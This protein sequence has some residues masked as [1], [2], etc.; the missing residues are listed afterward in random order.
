[1]TDEVQEAKQAYSQHLDGINSATDAE[2]DEAVSALCNSA[3]QTREPVGYAGT[4]GDMLGRHAQ[5]PSPHETIKMG[6]RTS[7]PDPMF[8]RPQAPPSPPKPKPDLS[9]S[10]MRLLEDHDRCP[11]QARDYSRRQG[12]M[13]LIM[14]AVEQ[15]PVAQQKGLFDG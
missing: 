15:P 13:R 2:I 10:I 14:Q 11:P 4:L 6:K 1:M 12:T 7:N 5:P 8:P 3:R 9:T